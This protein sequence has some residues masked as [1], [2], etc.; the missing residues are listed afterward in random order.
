MALTALGYTCRHTLTDEN[1]GIP[2]T[3]ALF[4]HLISFRLRN[5][6]PASLLSNP[7]ASEIVRRSVPPTYTQRAS[8]AAGH[9][10]VHEPTRHPRYLCKSMSRAATFVGPYTVFVLCCSTPIHDVVRGLHS[11][12]S[13]LSIPWFTCRWTGTDS[14]SPS[15]ESGKQAIAVLHARGT[16]LP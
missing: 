13:I 7:H 9:D 3:W 11:I 5:Y 1:M 2:K 4:G 15:V 12:L 14:R 16:S 6:P 10:D 8:N